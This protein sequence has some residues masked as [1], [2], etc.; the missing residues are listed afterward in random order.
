MVSVPVSLRN[1][2]VT[3]RP[4]HRDLRASDGLR[5]RDSNGDTAI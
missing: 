2:L 1:R 4:F 3:A 5:R